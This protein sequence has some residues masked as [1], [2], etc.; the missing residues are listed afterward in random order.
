MCIT[1]HDFV[2]EG[3]LEYPCSQ[4]DQRNRTAGPLRGC[5]NVHRARLRSVDGV[6]V[7]LEHSGEIALI[8]AG[9]QP[10]ATDEDAVLVQR[11]AR[12]GVELV[13]GDLLR[14]IVRLHEAGE[15][16]AL[17]SPDLGASSYGVLHRGASTFLCPCLSRLAGRPF[18]SQLSFEFIELALE[19]IAQARQFATLLRQLVGPITGFILDFR[20]E[21]AFLGRGRRNLGRRSRLPKCRLGK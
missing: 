19:F 3:N 4:G 11:S 17:D 12:R 14:R 20:R 18:F 5:L 8:Q 10:G 9:A 2:S 13:L 1:L 6:D 21:C 15:G 7:H 16:E